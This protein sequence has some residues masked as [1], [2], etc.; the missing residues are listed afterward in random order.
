MHII[1][2]LYNLPPKLTTRALPAQYFLELS[3]S[4]VHSLAS[5]YAYGLTSVCN[6]SKKAIIGLLHVTGREV[7][8]CESA[9]ARK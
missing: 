3:A 2:R 7:I 5:G 4:G 8:K 9:K 6:S 1:L